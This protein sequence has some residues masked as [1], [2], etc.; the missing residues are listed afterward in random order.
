MSDSTLGLLIGGVAPALLLGFFFVFQ[1]LATRKG[2][3]PGEYL[4]VLG[5]TGSAIGGILIFTGKP[6]EF[7][8][9]GSVWTVLSSACWGISMAGLAYSIFKYNT[10]MS[11][12]NPILN[13]NT[14]TAVILSIV[15]LGE[16][17]EINVYKVLV[18]AVLIIIGAITVS[19]A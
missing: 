11:K 3:G 1:K 15:I 10:P 2:I 18:G 9:I 5:L 17:H 7:T 13:T 8:A 16:W 4:M 14:L 19:R 6:V 12:L